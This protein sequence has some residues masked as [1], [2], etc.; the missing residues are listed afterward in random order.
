M[1]FEVNATREP[2]WE[3]LSGID[4][5]SRPYYLYTPTINLLHFLVYKLS[6]G[7]ADEWAGFG[8]GGY[9]YF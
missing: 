6:L 9:T 7:E 1:I 8:V 2:S 3:I 4:R 5:I